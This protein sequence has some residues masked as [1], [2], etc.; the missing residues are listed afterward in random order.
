MSSSQSPRSRAAAARSEPDAS[1]APNTDGAEAAPVAASYEAALSELESLVGDMESGRLALEA[2]LAAYQRGS[3][4]LR[5]C[6]AQLAAAEHQVRILE[7]DTLVD[8]EGE[9]HQD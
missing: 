3:T 8:A 1:P 5:Y 4:L 9:D 2:S 7:G 6:Q